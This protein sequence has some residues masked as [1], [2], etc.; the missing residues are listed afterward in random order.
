MNPVRGNQ[1]VLIDSRVDSKMM[2]YVWRNQATVTK[3]YL[4][5]TG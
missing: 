4:P 5:L 2:N 1:V 3:G